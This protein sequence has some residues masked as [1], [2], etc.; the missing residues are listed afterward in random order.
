[1]TLTLNAN[2]LYFLNISC[3]ISHK[4]NWNVLDSCE[5]RIADV[6]IVDAI[7]TLET[8][9]AEGRLEEYLQGPHL[10]YALLSHPKMTGEMVERV[11]MDL[12]V[13]GVESV[14]LFDYMVWKF[15]ALNKKTW[16]CITKCCLSHPQLILKEDGGTR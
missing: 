2:W 4:N 6:A 12:F 3:E 11:L 10:L 16:R 9:R 1:M 15:H 7:Q 5:Q 8:A 13:A 14:R